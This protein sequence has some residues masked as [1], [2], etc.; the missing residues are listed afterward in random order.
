MEVL[1]KVTPHSLQ[2]EGPYESQKWTNFKLVSK[3]SKN[4]VFKLK[5]TCLNQSFSKY[6]VD[7]SSPTYESFEVNLNYVF[8]FL[9][10]HLMEKTLHVCMSN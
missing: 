1:L 8:L 7:S 10:K 4:Q 2:V 9:L 5:T 6:V 3:Q